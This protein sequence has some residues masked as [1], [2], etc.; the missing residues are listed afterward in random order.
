[1]DTSHSETVTLAISIYNGQRPAQGTQPPWSRLPQAQKNTW[2]NFAYRRLVESGEIQ[3]ASLKERIGDKSGD[4]RLAFLGYPLSEKAVEAVVNPGGV[5]VPAAISSAPLP[6]SAA[7][8]KVV[9]I[10]SGFIDYF[11]DAIAAV[12]RLSQIGNDQ[13]NPGKPLHWDRSKSGDESDALMRH[14]LERGT[15]DTDGVRHSAKVA[16]R[17]LALLQKE[18]EAARQISPDIADRKDLAR[19]MMS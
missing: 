4:A 15:I 11:P 6:T 5:L 19:G 13:H 8:R 1:M 3:D 7:E 2:L 10:A 16:W 18:I 9:P 14:F 12:A 17:A